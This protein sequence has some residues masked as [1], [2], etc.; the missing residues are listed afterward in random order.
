MNKT[1][2]QVL[3]SEIESGMNMISNKENVSYRTLKIILDRAYE[4]LEKE[5][6]QIIDAVNDSIVFSSAEKYF[7]QK[8]KQQP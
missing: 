5:K 1:A 6:Q 4:L 8:Y 2:M 3:I 7:N